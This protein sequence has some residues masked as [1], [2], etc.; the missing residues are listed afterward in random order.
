MLLVGERGGRQLATHL[1]MCQHLCVSAKETQ[2]VHD[3]LPEEESKQ[4]SACIFI[5]YNRASTQTSVRRPGWGSGIDSEPT[6]KRIICR[7]VLVLS[8]SRF[9]LDSKTCR[10]LP[11]PLEWR[12]MSQHMGCQSRGRDKLLSEIFHFARQLVRLIFSFWRLAEGPV[13]DKRMYVMKK[14][15]LSSW[16]AWC[17]EM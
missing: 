10:Q 11:K 17:K 12:S 6:L 8:F 4:T 14:S 3:N 13:F 16:C 2:S 7:D 15:Q 9:H 1:S 5:R